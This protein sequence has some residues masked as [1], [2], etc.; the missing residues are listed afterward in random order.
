MDHRDD[1]PKDRTRRGPRAALWTVQVLLAA[2]FLY[3]S[4]NKLSGAPQ[5]I[6]TFEAIGLGQW[7]RY[8]TGALELAGAIGLLL[9]RLAGL[10]ALGLF[11]VMFGAF[12]TEVFVMPDGNP[13][14]PLVLLLVTAT[15]A[16]LLRDRTRALLPGS[17]SGLGPATSR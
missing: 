3:F 4:Y 16:W 6:E 7:L 1:T 14:L 5:T 12:A 8:L 17:A 2:A 15:L 9:P 10:A 13:V 11:G